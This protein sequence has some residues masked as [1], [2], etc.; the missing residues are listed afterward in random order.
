MS[1]RTASVECPSC[2]KKVLMTEA[3]A[4]RPFCSKRCKD[5][6]FGGWANESYQ[7]ASETD[8]EHWSEEQR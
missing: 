2:G 6:D 4:Y 8:D 1:V 7:I 3:F 5:I